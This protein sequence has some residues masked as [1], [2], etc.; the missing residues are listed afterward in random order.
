MQAY[1]PVKMWALDLAVQS[2]ASGCDAIDM[3]IEYLD[4]AADCSDEDWAEFSRQ[5]SEAWETP[6][7]T[8]RWKSAI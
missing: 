7:W 1:D 8:K 6:T 5:V 2:G 4:F 3:A